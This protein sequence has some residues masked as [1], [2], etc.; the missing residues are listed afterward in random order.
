MAWLH[1]AQ[2]RAG[3]NDAEALGSLAGKINL[4]QWPGTLVAYFLGQ[5]KL[6]EVSA[7][8]NHG[9]MGR[10]RECSLS[11]FAGED[12]LAKDNTE[13]ARQPMLRAREVCNPHT[14]QYLVA[15]VELERMKK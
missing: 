7:A 13:Q 8:S 14:F 1:I 9:A 5:I 4:K 15:G 12:A 2:A 6:E 3:R 11:L 10:G